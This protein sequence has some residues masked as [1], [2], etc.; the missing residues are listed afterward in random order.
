MHTW[1]VC[2]FWCNWKH[3][4][5]TPILYSNAKWPNT[6]GIGLSRLY[7][8]DRGTIDFLNTVNGIENTFTVEHILYVSGIETTLLLIST[9]TDVSLSVHFIDTQVAISQNQTT[10]IISERIDKRIYHLDI[11]PQRSNNN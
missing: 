10:L 7:V 6:K 5:Q 2:R 9:V 11:C 8:R 1:L 4:W 3:D